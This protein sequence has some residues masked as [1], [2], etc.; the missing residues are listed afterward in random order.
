VPCTLLRCRQA[1]PGWFEGCLHF[2][3]EQ[4]MFDL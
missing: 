1:S 4:A 3:R 2:N